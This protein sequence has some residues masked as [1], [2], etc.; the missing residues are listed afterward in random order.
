[1]AQIQFYHLTTTPLERALPKLLEKAVSGGYR[2]LLLTKHDEQAEQLNQLLW[3]YDPASFLP[4]GTAT[5]ANPEKQPV[6]ISASVD[7]PN[8]ANL[9]AVVSG[10]TC[11]TPNSFERVLDMFDGKDP[12]AVESAR[13]RWKFYKESGHSL[14]YL[15]QTENGGWEQKAVA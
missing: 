5:A 11:E 14:T 2:V 9:L 10:A 3:T 13:N 12:Q 6:L 8:Q 1:M 7:A 4:H 15:R